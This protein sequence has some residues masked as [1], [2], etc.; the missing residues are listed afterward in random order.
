M[1]DF[2][3]DAFSWDK[4]VTMNPVQ[5]LD[6]AFTF[7]KDQLG[8]EKLL[9]PEGT[10]VLSYSEHICDSGKYY[11]NVFRCKSKNWHLHLLFIAPGYGLT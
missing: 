5:R 3:P 8:I 7:A 6:H 4:V 9:D 11:R 2:R 10:V 1:C